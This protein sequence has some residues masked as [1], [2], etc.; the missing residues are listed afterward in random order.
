MVAMVVTL[1]VREAQVLPGVDTWAIWMVGLLATMGGSAIFA[2]ATWRA[3]V[4]SRPAAAALGAGGGGMAVM[5]LLNFAGVEGPDPIFILGPLLSLYS[6]GW[7]GLGIRAL[8][9]GRLIPEVGSAL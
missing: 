8:R 6:A 7:F 5:L 1:T 3:N 4:L 2:I 9:G